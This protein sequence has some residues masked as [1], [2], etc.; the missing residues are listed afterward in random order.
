MDGQFL[1]ISTVMVWSGS[2]GLYLERLRPLH[3]REKCPPSTPVRQPSLAGSAEKFVPVSGPS[4]TS[5]MA[6]GR[7][8]LGQKLLAPDILLHGRC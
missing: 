7:T 5:P 6:P 8:E 3:A 1:L 4:E 2:T